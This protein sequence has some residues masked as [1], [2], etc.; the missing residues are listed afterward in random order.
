M[1]ETRDK[2][3]LLIS[4]DVI[5]EWLDAIDVAEVTKKSYRCGLR[6]L[7][8][9]ALENELDIDA[10]ETADVV[11]F[12]KDLLTRLSPGTVS[13]YLKGV[14]SFYRWAEND[15]FPDVASKVKGAPLSRDFKK[16]TLTREQAK[17]LLE[18]TLGEGEQE[19]RDHAILSLML[20]TGLRD[21]EVVRADVGDMKPH[22]GVMVLFVHGKGRSEKDDF[23]VLTEALQ[24]DI[25]RYL[26][27]RKDLSPADPLF[28]STSNR[29][30]GGRLTTR[31]VSGIVKK[32]LRSIGLDSER[33]TA[34]SL[35]HTSVTYALLGG[36]TVEEAQKMARHADISTTMVYAHHVDRVRSN[37]EARVSSFLDEAFND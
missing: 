30:R 1:T 35:R 12:K 10:L 14:K 18:T 15:A 32:A 27:E 17:S 33:Y 34:H 4:A 22:S 36:A 13:T 6:S 16:D 29:N 21:I 37:A 5:A 23:V 2:E 9:Y 3:T 19:K 24:A 8:E 7:E 31:S 11:A 20:R 26:A 25:N 28:A